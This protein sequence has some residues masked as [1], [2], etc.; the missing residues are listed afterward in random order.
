MEQ[1]DKIQGE[2]YMTRC[3]K[4]QH[5]L[6]YM[7]DPLK[8]E[9]LLNFVELDWFYESWEDMR[10][11]DADLSA[12]QVTIM[13]QPKAGDVIQ[14]TRGVRKLR[15]S[16]EA[17]NTGKSGALRVCYVHF[18]KYGIVLLAF[19]YKK[20]ELATLSPK[21]IKTINATIERIEE[22]LQMSFGL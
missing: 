17:W 6:V 3:S 16:P 21:S 15:F 9:D 18:E 4:E 8:P 19:V 12:L 22:R 2:G 10:L 11:S 13:C 20:G 7:E 14:G 5:T 1:D